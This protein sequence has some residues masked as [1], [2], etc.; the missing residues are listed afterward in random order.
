MEP[1]PQ[2]AVIA[3]VGF[4]RQLE[5]QGATRRMKLPHY[6]VRSVHA[7]LTLAAALCISAAGLSLIAQ[8]AQK[9]HRIE[10]LFLGT[11][12]E[13]HSAQRATALLVPA[14]AEQQLEGGRYQLR[15][16]HRN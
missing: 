8:T 3:A 7:R 13:E 16:V 10:V 14:L 12:V 9:G 11:E 2:R 5:I 6:S 1:V 4:R 15:P